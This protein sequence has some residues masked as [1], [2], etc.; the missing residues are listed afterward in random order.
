MAKADI[1]ELARAW[2]IPVWNRPS[3]ACLASRIPYGTPVTAA[4]L[5]MIDQMEHHLRVVCRYAQVRSRHHGDV[6]RIELPNDALSALLT[7][8]THREALVAVYAA[9]GYARATIDLR[10]F[11]SGSMN[12]V[13]SAGDCPTSDAAVRMQQE[14]ALI[15]AVPAACQAQ[16][17]MLCIQVP[18]G[19]FARIASPDLR[20]RLVRRA[21]EHGF[22]YLALDLA[23]LPE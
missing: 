1:R 10:G 8:P 18:C 19:A 7:N 12:E 20:D 16:G 5:A 14:L 17:Q 13:L 15:G 23:P 9:A 21:E 2:G 22:R 3:A 11:R 4:A 6:A